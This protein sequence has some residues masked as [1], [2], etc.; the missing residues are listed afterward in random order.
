M[1]QDQGQ[2]TEEWRP[3][4]GYEDA[5]SVSD[6]GRVRREAR[7]RGAKPGRILSTRVCPKDGRERVGI[8]AGNR[9]R[10]FHVH[11]LVAMAWVGG[12]T[13]ERSEVNHKNGVQHDNRAANLEWVTRAENVQHA[14]DTGLF[15]APRGERQHLAKLDP[16]RVRLIRASGESL[17]AIARR[18]RVAQTTVFNI[19]HRR[20]WRHVE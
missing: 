10:T 17:N 5:Y 16:E 2:H 20:T 3:I 11:R 9:L 15:E 1:I 4:V 7:T 6:L 12:R 13:E 18:F 19:R 8:S 14:Y